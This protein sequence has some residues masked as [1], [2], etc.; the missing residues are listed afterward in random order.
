MADWTPTDIPALAGRRAIVTGANSGLGYEVALELARHGADTVLACRAQS[1][2]DEALSRIQRAVPDATVTTG[3]LDL[4][5]LD[6]V[7]AFAAEHAAGPPIRILVNN[8]GVMAVPRQY[9]KDGFELQLATNH[10]GHFALTGLLLPALLAEPG[11]RVVSVSSGVAQ[12]SRIDF[13]DLQSRRGYHRWTAY[14]QSK[15]ANLL[16]AFELDR[17]AE[18][19]GRQLVSV[20][21]HPGYAAT[22]L[23][24]A[25]PAESGNWFQVRTMELTNFLF[26][27]SA[28]QGAQPLLYAA[29]APDVHGGEYYGPRWFFGTRGPVSR[30]TPPGRALDRNAAARLWSVSEE[31]TAVSFDL[32]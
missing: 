24:T 26:A 6:S 32:L 18:G 19:A 1:R 30:A 7:R 28:A 21:A 4:A 22:N 27:Q 23:Q 10:L 5:E 31:L 8:A 13:D 2:A 3:L 9:T 15:L 29:T 11:S 20:A 12:W 17:R 14:A 16:F 25:A